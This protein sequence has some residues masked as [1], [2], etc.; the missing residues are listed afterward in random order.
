MVEALTVLALALLAAGVVG[1]VVPALPGPLLSLSGVYLHWWATGYTEPGALVLVSLSL[2][3]VLALATDLLA[4]A[5]STRAGGASWPVSAAAGLAGVVLFFVAGPVGVVLGV[6]GTVFVLSL[7]TTGDARDSA[8][9]AVY[10]TVGVLGSAL[11]QALLTLSMLAA[12]ALVLF[13]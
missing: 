12:F 1:S 2:V 8:R 4:S 3:G 9:A 13:V 5:V 10:A 11:V 6:A 7:A